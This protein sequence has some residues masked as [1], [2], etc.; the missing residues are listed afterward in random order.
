M[1]IHRKDAWLIA[2]DIADPRRLQRIHKVVS[3]FAF[4]VQYSLYLAIA[5]PSMMRDFCRKLD[6]LI[7]S[8]KDDVRVY[9]V[10]DEPFYYIVG[11]QRTSQ[12][13]LLP[14]TL[15]PGVRRFVHALFSTDI[16]SRATDA[17][18]PPIR[19]S[20]GSLDFLESIAVSSTYNEAYNPLR[21]NRLT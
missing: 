3:G 19:S 13:L 10:P 4:A 15:S 21:K 8:R 18:P 11:R 6:V 14:S 1:P 12:L 9:H 2:Y 7:D 5:S 20:H 17:P 16:Q